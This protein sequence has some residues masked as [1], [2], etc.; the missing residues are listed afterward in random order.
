MRQHLNQYVFSPLFWIMSLLLVGLFLLVLLLFTPIGPKTIAYIADSSVDELSLKGV[1]GSVLT[2]LHIDEFAWDSEVGII[3]KDINVTIDSY[4]VENKKIFADNLTVGELAIVIEENTSEVKTSDAPIELPD[5]GFPINIDAN[6]LQLDS[7]KIIKKTPA[8]ET[9]GKTESD[10][11][12]LLFQIQGIILNKATIKEGILNYQSLEGAPI[13]L[14]QPLKIEVANGSLNMNRPHEVNTSGAISFKHPTLGDLSGKILLGGTLT[15]YTFESDLIFSQAVI[16]DGTLKVNGVGDYKNVKLEG[17]DLESI[18]G[19]AN[20]NGIV[21]WDPEIRLDF[22]I[23]AKQLSSKKLLPDWPV[24]ADAK[25]KYQGSFIDSRLENE[26]NILSLDGV[27][28]DQK[29]SG[30]GLVLNKPDLTRVEKLNLKLGQNSVQL[31][32]E[33]LLNL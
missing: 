7:L 8:V 28:K 11:Q 1:T 6:K 21:E 4:D 3:V 19:K 32:R 20:G 31:H 18:H 16:G 17:I 24:T 12:S 23:D 22:D 14:D 9:A 30:N 10:L 15:N 13:I 5:F 27:Y 26:I 2:G 25:I 33:L 29:I